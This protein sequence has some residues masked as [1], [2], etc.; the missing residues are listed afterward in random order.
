MLDNK[1]KTSLVRHILC[2]KYITHE[3]EQYNTHATHSCNIVNFISDTFVFSICHS[4]S[5][6]FKTQYDQTIPLPGL[7][8]I[9]FKYTGISPKNRV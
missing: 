7:V 8:Y 2:K 3:N 5:S 9:C 6:L 4:G 1:S